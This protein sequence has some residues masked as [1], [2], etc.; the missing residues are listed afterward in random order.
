[1][2]NLEW[3]KVK[4]VHNVVTPALL[5]YPERIEKNIHKMI[6][7]AGGTEHL[8]PHIKTHKM[9]EIIKI[10]MHRGI[11]KFKCATLTEAKLLAQCGAEDVLL[12]LQPVGP[13][14]QR[15]CDLMEQF[16]NT[17]F[18]TITDNETSIEAF[19]QIASSINKKIAL[20]LDVNNGMDRTGIVPGNKA[21]ELYKAIEKNP[22][23]IAKGLHVYDGHIRESDFDQ[24]KKICDTDFS[25]VL[26]LKTDL[27]KLGIRVE[28]IIAG[29][30][31]SFPVHAMRKNIVT[32]PGTPMLWDAGYGRS[33]KDL[34]FLYAAV[35][36][37]RIIGKP[38]QDL[39]CLDLGHKSVASEMKLPRVDILGLEGSEQIG[40]SEEHLVVR[41]KNADNF[42]VGDVFYAIPIHICPTVSKYPEALTVVDGRVTGAWKVAA[43]DH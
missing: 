1:M 17:E 23:L 9:A 4:D 19:D 34:N 32:S 18:S 36:L 3:Y 24:R 2:N 10:Q 39:L 28:N 8:R 29:G 21:I 27:E 35:L 43:R 38:Q 5:I 6:G 12:A 15:F 26:K 14:I 41:C 22:N 25:P 20:W 13:N 33:F 40:Q 37:T 7:I 31:P 42:K 30:T 11:H 16:P